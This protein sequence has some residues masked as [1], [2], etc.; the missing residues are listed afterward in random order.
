MKEYLFPIRKVVFFVFL[1]SSLGLK[2]QNIGE[3]TNLLAIVN[4]VT[5]NSVPIESKEEYVNAEMTIT[6]PDHLY[7]YSGEIQIRGRGNHTWEVPPK[8]PYKIKLNKKASLMGLPENK[9]W[10]LMAHWMTQTWSSNYFA[11]EMAR[12]IGM[13]WQP[14]MVPV[15][16]IL[17]GQFIGLYF[18]QETIRIVEGRLDIFEQKDGNIDSEDLPYG[19]LVEVDNSI[20]EGQVNVEEWPGGPINWITPHSPEDL[21]SLQYEWLENEFTQLGLESYIFETDNPSLFQHIDITSLARY[22]LVRDILFDGDAYYGSWYFHKDKGEDSKWIVGP[23]W[24][25]QLRFR[26][27]DDLLLNSLE[28]FTYLTRFKY[29]DGIRRYPQYWTAVYEEWNKFFPDQFEETLLYLKEMQE[30]LAIPM[31]NDWAVWPSQLAIVDFTDSYTCYEEIETALRGNAQIFDEALLRQ[32][33]SKEAVMPDD[34]EIERLGN[35]FQIRG[36]FVSL[37]AYNVLGQKLS[38]Y[39]SNSSAFKISFGNSSVV[40]IKAITSSGETIERKIAR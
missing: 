16:V 5:E 13:G 27:H 2:S 21:N 19:W 20:E 14:H 34:I 24:D 28:I 26:D 37:D 32:M 36:N 12:K 35:E 3:P 33:A 7:D 39:E 6:D 9:H 29:M 17:N 4:I 11:F 10:A 8:K 31:E 40:I 18:I 38:I 23:M 25:C 15:E 22:S 30:R 1:L